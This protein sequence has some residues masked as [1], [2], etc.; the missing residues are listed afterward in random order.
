VPTLLEALR[1]ADVRVD[2]VEELHPT[3]DDVFV[4]LMETADAREGE[5]EGGS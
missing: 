3:F 4:R 5:H 1:A 2:H